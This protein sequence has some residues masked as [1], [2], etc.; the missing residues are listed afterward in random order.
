MM[1][2][3]ETLIGL[4]GN[5]ATGK[6]VVRRMLVNF[7]A[8][9]LDADVI[10]HRTL[11]PGG[12]AY[13]SVVDTFGE[14]LLDPRGEISRPALGKV[15][16]SYPNRLRK[17]ES[18]IHPAVTQ[19][20]KKRIGQAKLPLTVIE[21]IKLFESPLI[22]LCNLVWISDAAPEVQMERLLQTRNMSEAD[23]KARIA[24]Q[25]PQEEKRKRANAVIHT[26]GEFAQTWQQVQA[27]LNDTIY[28]KV[29]SV[30]PNIKISDTCKALPAGKLPKAYL[31]SFWADNAYESTADLYKTLAFQAVLALTNDQRLESLLLIEEHNFTAS[32][33]QAITPNRIPPNLQ[34]WLTTFEQYS[35]LH[36]TEL[37]I[38]P[39]T[40]TK[41]F[42]EDETIMANGFTRQTPDT[43][44]FPAWRDAANRHSSGTNQPLWVKVIAQPFN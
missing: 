41:S 29:A 1:T 32:L 5:I 26:E 28:S 4:T 38:L 13:Q 37:L 42:P 10:A 27:A 44:T 22:D 17:L 33:S 24:A 43:L 25:P 23:A 16:F 12:A 15:V 35:L 31:A 11:Y 36:Q 34:D 14:K 3:N 39:D 2:A 18:L 7:G 30:F 9:G 40:F 21:A 20:I 6:S 8:L 19:T